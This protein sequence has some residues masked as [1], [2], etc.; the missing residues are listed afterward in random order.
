MAR[1][2]GKAVLVT[3][4][5]QRIGRAIALAC[6]RA[7]ADV[8]ITYLTSEREARKTSA[9]IER[10]GRR[11]LAV[12]C[13]IRQQKSITAT[14][15]QVVREFQRLDVLVSNAGFYETADFD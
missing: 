13:D 6:A 15:K 5:A 7:G 8:A 14:V 2:E 11:A 9:E 10:L 4:G 1:L 12:R 3:G